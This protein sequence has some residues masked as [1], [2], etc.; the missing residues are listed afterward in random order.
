MGSGLA[1]LSLPAPHSPS[2]PAERSARSARSAAPR[3]AAPVGGAASDWARSSRPTWQL[4][5]RDAA[6]LRWLRSQSGPGSGGGLGKN[7]PSEAP[8]VFKRNANSA[9]GREDL[10]IFTVHPP[11][12]KKKAPSRQPP[13][14]ATAF[15]PFHGS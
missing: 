10:A 13:C 15:G 7:Q 5:G 14:R 6:P 1:T 2:P 12:S 11:T 9:E 3:W 4:D 8:G